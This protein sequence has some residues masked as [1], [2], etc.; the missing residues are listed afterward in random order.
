VLRAHF[1]IR[2]DHPCLPDHF[3][4]NPIAPGVLT[5]DHVSR[6]LLVQVAGM[7]VAGFPQV[8]FMRPVLSAV[9]V[10][11]TYIKKSDTLYQFKC[12]NQGETLL[13]GQIRLAKKERSLV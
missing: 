5:L 11:V 13:A 10:E 7:Y 2:K 4:G 3:P 9:E 12:E 6:C 8:K 1:T